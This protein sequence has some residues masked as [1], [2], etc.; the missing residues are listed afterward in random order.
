MV[1]VGKFDNRTDAEFARSLLAAAGIPCVLAPDETTG[2][3]PSDRS[4]CARLL[5]AEADAEDAAVVLR[6]HALSDEDRR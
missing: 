5:V 6:H 4:C 2:A 1:E 3:Y